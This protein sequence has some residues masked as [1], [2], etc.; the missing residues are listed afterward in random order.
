VQ[1][2]ADYIGKSSG[3]VREAMTLVSVLQ[4]L[5]P[6]TAEPSEPDDD[7]DDDDDAPPDDEG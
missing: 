5:E 1:A 4:S 3:P 2:L 7:D 6:V